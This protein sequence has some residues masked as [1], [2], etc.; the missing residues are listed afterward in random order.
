MHIYI[1]IVSR[2]KLKAPQHQQGG[3]WS[4]FT[5][6]QGVCQLNSVD[7]ISAPWI[8][9]ARSPFSPFLPCMAWLMLSES[10]RPLSKLA[11]RRLAWLRFSFLLVSFLRRRCMV[12]KKC[13]SS[14]RMQL[15]VCGQCA[16]CTGT[17]LHYASA[18]S[19]LLGQTWSDLLAKIWPKF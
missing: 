6:S 14:R 8:P 5:P 10:H 17:L 19:A 16:P 7:R 18:V 2:S 13:M 15:A 9:F 1:Y 12:E 4:S 11:Q 3:F